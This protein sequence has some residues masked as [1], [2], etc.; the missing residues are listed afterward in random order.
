MGPG[1][2]HTKGITRALFP[3]IIEKGIR[4]A[5]KSVGN[6]WHRNY[7]YTKRLLSKKKYRINHKS[8]QIIIQIYWLKMF[9]SQGLY[10]TFVYGIPGDSRY[11]LRQNQELYIYKGPKK[12]YFFQNK[13]QSIWVRDAWRNM[14]FYQTIL[15]L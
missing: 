10:A 6:I 4:Q 9:T 12:L 1:T 7:I 3:F 5:C 13:V 8:S 2:T 15:I 11:Y 14:L